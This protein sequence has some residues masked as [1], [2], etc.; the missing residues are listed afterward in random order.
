MINE[1]NFFLSNIIIFLFC[2]YFFV[3]WV[4]SGDERK[5]KK[6][7]TKHFLVFVCINVQQ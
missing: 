6:N 4:A 3:G 1:I 5:Y 2:N 7:A